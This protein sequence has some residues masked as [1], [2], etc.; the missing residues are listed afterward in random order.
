MQKTLLYTTTQRTKGGEEKLNEKKKK[1]KK[2]RLRPFF[3]EVWMRNNLGE[4]KK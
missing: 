2:G 4:K 3:I 1:K